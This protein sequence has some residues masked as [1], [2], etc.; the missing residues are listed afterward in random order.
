MEDWLEEDYIKW[1][2]EIDNLKLINDEQVNYSV[3]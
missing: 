3:H 2:S 1:I